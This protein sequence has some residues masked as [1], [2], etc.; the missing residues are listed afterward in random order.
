MHD[1]PTRT[2][3][4]GGGF[5]GLFT[6]LQLQHQGYSLPVTLV[7]REAGFI[8]KP[9]LYELLSGEMTTDQ[10]WPRYEDLLRNSHVR[11]VQDSVEAIDLEKREVS[12]ASGVRYHYGRLVLALGSVTG[13]FGAEGARENTFAFRTGEDA[14]AL[15]HH[16]RTL[17]QRASQVEAQAERSALLTVAVIGGGPAGVELSATLADLLPEWYKSLGGD[18]YEI[19]VVL[20][21]RGHE[22]LPGDMNSRLRQTA[23]TSLRER[24]VPVTV[25]D[26]AEVT[27]VHPDRL[28]YKIQGEVQ[29]LDVKTVVWT[30]GTAIHPLIE[31]LPIPAQNRDKRGRLEVTPTLQLPDF[32][33]VFAGGDCTVDR[34][35]QTS[36]G[37]RQDY[38]HH[39]G[40]GKH[41]Q[42]LA[43]LPA[44]AQVAYQQGTAI[45]RNLQAIAEGRSPQ[46]V[47]VSL[48][49]TLL[50][51]GLY[52]SAAEI[53]DRFEVKGR[54][55]HLIR[56][57]TYLELLPTPAH[58]LKVTAEWLVDEIFHR[59]HP[60]AQS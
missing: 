17:L 33:E 53:F 47:H 7:E 43:P 45:A 48:R 19:R 15:L 49:G 27:A 35:S 22:I 5:T 39:Q 23:Q 11:F 56:Q 24:S 14:L 10:V 36:K 9:L 8:F 54:A 40:D 4:L 31:S 52:E 38:E 50:K 29:T 16:L 44:T 20:L 6:A 57:G 58:N 41:P 32:P 13:Y 37:H 12:L 21:S 28:E 60:I 42:D 3:I 46:A 59:Y 34:P 18:I 55:G 26:G 25:I 2:I 51:L 1:D 30:A